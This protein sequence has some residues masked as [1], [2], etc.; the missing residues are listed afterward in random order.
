MLW[1]YNLSEGNISF[2]PQSTTSWNS[3]CYT[4]LPL[5]FNI[6]AE[7]IESVYFENWIWARATRGEKTVFSHARKSQ[8]QGSELTVLLWSEA[9]CQSR[10]MNYS[11]RRHVGQTQTNDIPVVLFSIWAS[12]KFLSLSIS[13][14]MSHIWVCTANTCEENILHFFFVYLLGHGDI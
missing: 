5:I 8:R 11:Q 3:C 9:T 2:K 14:I 6:H 1:I 12:H 7:I 13:F 10:Q 4:L